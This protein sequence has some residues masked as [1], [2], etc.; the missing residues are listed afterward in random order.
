MASSSFNSNYYSLAIGDASSSSSL[1]VIH[2]DEK[3]REKV[4]YLVL[5]E[6]FRKFVQGYG[7]THTTFRDR[8]ISAHAGVASL[9]VSTA[10][11]LRM[12]KKFCGGAVGLTATQV[13]LVSAK[14]VH[15]VLQRLK[16]LDAQ[17]EAGL[18]DMAAHKL[19]HL[20][21]LHI[22]GQPAVL[23]VRSQR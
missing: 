5:L 7:V 22:N 4:Q 19:S 15:R 1:L 23:E 14:V 18:K 16:A 21:Q 11:E 6:V 8:C 17:L 2:R 3:Q 20:R 9:P 13:Q 10:E 12:A